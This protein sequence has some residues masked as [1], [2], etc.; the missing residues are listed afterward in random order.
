MKP[1]AKFYTTDGL[2][3][4]TLLANLDGIIIE[5]PNGNKFELYFNSGEQALALSAYNDSLRIEPR[6]ANLIYLR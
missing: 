3:Q 5:L 6:A 2:N 1:T 4:K